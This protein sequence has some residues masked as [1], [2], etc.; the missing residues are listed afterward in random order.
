VEALVSKGFVV[1]EICLLSA[2][3]AVVLAGMGAGRPPTWPEAATTAGALVASSLLVAAVALRQSVLHPYRADLR[4]ARDTPAPPVV[5][6]GHALR[7]TVVASTFCVALGIGFQLDGARGSVLLV[8]AAVC[9]GCWH[10]LRTRARW[11][12]P[13]VRRQ[14]VVRVASG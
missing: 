8:A 2:T 12:D 5:M 11:E 13:G 14:V 1:V 7:L 6:A 10:V 3:L 9:A 4:S